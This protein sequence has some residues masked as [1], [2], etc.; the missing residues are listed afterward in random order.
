MTFA[1]YNYKYK[2]KI[3]VIYFL[4]S[5]NNIELCSKIYQNLIT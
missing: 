5:I 2:V 1:M 3:F 4:Y